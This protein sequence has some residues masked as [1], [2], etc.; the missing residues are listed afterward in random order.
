MVSSVHGPKERG[1]GLLT[2]T[3]P[4]DMGRKRSMPFPI[5]FGNPA[6]MIGS[7]SITKT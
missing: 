7:T 2:I 4:T 1:T 5:D 6:T 3:E